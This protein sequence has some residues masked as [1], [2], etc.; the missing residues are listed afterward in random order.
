[1]AGSEGILL[2]NLGTPDA[3]TVPAVRRYLGE[4]LSD[5][6]VI[7]MNPVGRWFL[8]HGVILRFRPR[9]SARAYQEVWTDE[10]SPLMVY[11]E[12]LAKGLEALRPERPVALAM[13]YGRPTL[14][15]AIDSLLARGAD[16]IC[17][18]PLFP[19]YASATT[20]SVMEAVGAE[21]S[22]RLFVPAVRTVAPFFEHP[23]F[24]R[25]FAEVWRPHLEASNPERVLF[26]YHGLPERQVRRADGT[27]HCLS[28]PDCCRVPCASSRRCYRAQC[29]ATTEHLRAAL[30]LP[31][32]QCHTSFQSRLG[33]IPWIQPYTDDR[34]MALR[35]EGVTRIAVA[36]P[37]FVAD[38]LETLEEIGMRAEESWK[39]AGGESLTLLP[40]LN[41]HP[42]WIRALD[43]IVSAPPGASGVEAALALGRVAERAV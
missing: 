1:M 35:A 42:A 13:R 31:E 43:E 30:G 8:L 22:R 23:S 37:A 14:A 24:V 40:S 41:A 26:S 6:R 39:E 21:L 27:G 4:F 18:V 33:R 29:F 34:L 32:S 12:A 16:Q 25:A 2:V 36:C 5:P 3:P 11:G 19:Q 28:R 38:C 17:V 9:A 20:G 10:G 7:D 15:G